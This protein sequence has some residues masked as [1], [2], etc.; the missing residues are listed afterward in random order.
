MKK[1]A[2]IGLGK[3]GSALGKKLLEAGFDLT[4]YNRTP[5]R[6]QPFL[7]MG[8]K[9]ADSVKEVAMAA[10]VVLTSLFDDDSVFD[11]VCG[12]EGL[13]AGL[14]QNA[15]HISTSTILP[16]T[17]KKL[18]ELHRDKNTIYVAANVLGIPK[19]ADKGEL[20]TIVAGDPNAV[21][22][23]TPLFNAYSKT[24]LNIGQQPYKAN[25]MK[26]CMN[27][28]LATSIECMA[29]V[30]TF[31]EKNDLEAEH[32]NKMFHTVFAHPAY[33]LYAVK[34]K[35]R[36]FDQVNFS[37][38]GGLKDLQL[39][40]KAFLQE[41]IVPDLANILVNKFIIALAHGMENKDWSAVSNVTRQLAGLE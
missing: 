2:L 5:S 24:I 19:V 34:I 31:A 13:L 9:G 7:Q 36:D 28:F 41:Q 30:Y 18:T 37:L 26:I 15:I 10:D 35:D 21:K 20:T 3:M 22:L 6:M 29:E 4:V 23:C 39:F 8:A 27:Y 16:A 25:V 1:V 32:I 17:S 14:K 12:P 33:Q 40:Q 11:V 38:R